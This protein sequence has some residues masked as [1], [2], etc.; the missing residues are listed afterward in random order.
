MGDRA[1]H[2]TAIARHEVADVRH[3]LRRERHPLL[4]QR[5]GG[6]RRLAGEGAHPDDLVR[7][8]D[9]TEPGDG[10]DV[11]EHDRAGEAHVQQ[12]NQAL[13]PREHLRVVSPLAEDLER[14]VHRRCADDLER[15]RLH[16]PCSWSSAQTRGGVSGSSTSSR[17]SA[18][19]TAFASAAGALIVFPSPS[20][21]APSGV[22]GRRS[23]AVG[24]PERRQIRRRRAEVVHEARGEEVPVLVVG[25]PL[26]QSRAGAV[27]EAASHLAVGEER[28]E[29]PAC[30]VD[31]RVVEHAHLAGRPLDLDDGDV[32]DE[33]VEGGGGDAVVLVGRVEVRRGEVGRRL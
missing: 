26:E 19:A 2:R 16:V 3:A 1:A 23:L 7:D 10:V 17:P 8:P 12:G 28:I 5:V 31:G 24:R 27:R 11:D 21:F 29:E 9:G 30:V 22:N 6:E 4:D 20:P 18:S 14:C 32:D 15:R 25:R 13:P 33:A